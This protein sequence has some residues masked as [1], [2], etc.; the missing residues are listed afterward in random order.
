MLLIFTQN[1]FSTAT[2]EIPMGKLKAIAKGFLSVYSFGFTLTGNCMPPQVIDMP[3]L[4]SKTTRIRMTDAEAI[5]N[6][7]QMVGNDLRA[8]MNSYEQT[9]E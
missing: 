1:V 9:Q 3:K 8:T 5:A 2:Y 6:D 7:W 4:P